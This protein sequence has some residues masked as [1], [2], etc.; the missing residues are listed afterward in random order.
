ML[1]NLKK[2][3]FL[4]LILTNIFLIV[5]WYVPTFILHN[6]LSYS[7]LTYDHVNGNPSSGIVKLQAGQK[8]VSE[9]TAVD[10]GLGIVLLHF[11][12]NPLYNQDQWAVRY[13]DEDDLVF[14]IKEVGAKEWYSQSGH[15]SGLTKSETDYPFGLPPIKDS[16]GKKY[17]IELE[18]TK[19]NEFNGVEIENKEVVSGYKYDLREL[20]QDKKKFWD[21]LIEKNINQLKNF[22]DFGFIVS[23]SFF[24][25]PLIFFHLMYRVFKWEAKYVTAHKEEI[26]SVRDRIARFITYHLQQILSAI[27][28]IYITIYAFFVTQINP[29]VYAELSL[30]AVA[31]VVKYRIKSK[32]LFIYSIISIFI[33]LIFLQFKLPFVDAEFELSYWAYFCLVFGVFLELANYFESGWLKIGYLINKVKYRNKIAVFSLVIALI[34]LLMLSVAQIGVE[35]KADFF[36][37]MVFLGLVLTFFYYARD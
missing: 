6:S 5:Y 21:F 19:G 11:K 26:H 1:K 29:L 32:V 22:E 10:N 12:R 4:V 14:R 37:T 33:S 27:I 3:R 13:E 8:Y 9:F 17:Q 7:V 20:F 30:L 34:F 23:S 16:K 2:L 36:A 25:L 24:I 31:V 18:S 35:F 15:R 28:L